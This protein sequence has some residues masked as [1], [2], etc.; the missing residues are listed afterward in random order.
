M[1]GK[2]GM[3]KQSWLNEMQ[4]CRS[5]ERCHGTERNITS[6]EPCDQKQEKQKMRE[7]SLG[8]VVENILEYKAMSR[9]A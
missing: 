3:D 9:Q 7:Y 6:F 2:V 5:P 4:I 1:L 8:Q